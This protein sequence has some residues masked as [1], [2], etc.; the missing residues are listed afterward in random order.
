MENIAAIKNKSLLYEDCRFYAIVIF[1][2]S[3]WSRV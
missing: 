3:L 1:C 2:V